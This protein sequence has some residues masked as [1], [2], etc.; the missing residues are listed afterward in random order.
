MQMTLDVAEQFLTFIE[1]VASFEKLC[2]LDR[3]GNINGELMDQGAGILAGDGRIRRICNNDHA[4]QILASQKRDDD[5]AFGVE[6]IVRHL[7][8]QPFLTAYVFEPRSIFHNAL[9]G[10][11]EFT[12]IDDPSE[13]IHSIMSHSVCA[14]ELV[15]FFIQQP[16]QESLAMNAVLNFLQ[17]GK[18][19]H[20]QLGHGLISLTQFQIEGWRNGCDK[21]IA[22]YDLDPHYPG[23]DRMLLAEL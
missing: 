6:I 5:I 1:L 20:I 17:D 10:C 23:I 21:G 14:F 2:V 16:D 12:A 3:N 19:D 18:H 13:H 7:L 11:G 15:S 9:I 22:H 8:L 4:D